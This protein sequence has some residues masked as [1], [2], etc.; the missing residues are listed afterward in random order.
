MGQWP[1]LTSRRADNSSKP[2]PLRSVFYPW[3]VLLDALLT[4]GVP[5]LL[6]GETVRVRYRSATGANSRVRSVMSSESTTT[7]PDRVIKHIRIASPPETVWRALTDPLLALRW[8]SDEPLELDTDWTVGG[9][10][11]LRGVLHGRLRFENSG[12]VQAFE[13]AR[14]LEYTHWN[15][16]SRRVLPDVPE[17][18]VV[19]RL[20]LMETEVGTEV[21]LTL[22]RL[23]N[24]AVYGHMNYYW[25]VALVALKRQCE[26]E[27]TESPTP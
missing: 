2:K 13:P 1:S 26:S 25:E 22:S 12:R 8:M 11:V 9:P 10:I 27:S 3:I 17:N 21:E 23:G 14:I 15:S 24:Y 19:I 18:H 6:L 4:H 7:F 16:L 5:Y 20:D